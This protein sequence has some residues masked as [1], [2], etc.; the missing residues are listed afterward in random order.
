MA[1][2]ELL[3]WK[4]TDWDFVGKRYI[5]FG[6]SACLLVVGA[7]AMVRIGTGKAKLAID[8]SGGQAI[9]AGIEGP[10][11]LDKVRGAFSARGLSDV[12]VQ[13]ATVQKGQRLLIKLR[14]AEMSSTTAVGT[15]GE[16]VRGILVGALPGATVV[17]EGVQA[18]GPAVGRRLQE[19]AMWAVIWAIV[20]IMVYIWIRFEYRFGLAAAVATLHD[21]IAVLGIMW[22]IGADFSLLIVTALLTLAGYSLT[23]T[24]V[25]Y[26]RIRENLR[27]HPAESFEVNVNRSINEV[28]S[29]TLVTSLMVLLPLIS[30]L[31]YGSPVTF[32]FSLSLSFGVIV[33]TYSSWYVASPLIVEWENYR[34]RRAAEAAANRMAGRQ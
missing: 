22:L 9:Q 24:V 13:Q 30:L 23:D 20:L 8:F 33:G 28:L 15:G 31:I 5:A 16:M 12:Q 2:Y 1:H 10:V 17:I 18:V 27:L 34:R 7:I 19:Q 6:F 3:G 26:D 25:V 29:R 32:D 4:K 11:D 14:G 21:V